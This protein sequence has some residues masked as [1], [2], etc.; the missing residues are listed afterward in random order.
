[1]QPWGTSPGLVSSKRDPVLLFYT[2][3]TIQSEAQEQEIS[4]SCALKDL[5]K[6]VMLNISSDLFRCVLGFL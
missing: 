2:C 6:N 3:S 1:M 5:N 4:G